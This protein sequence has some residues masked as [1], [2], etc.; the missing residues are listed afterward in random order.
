[1]ILRVSTNNAQQKLQ[2]VA[3]TIANK[4]PA[5]TKSKYQAAADRIRLPF[6]DWAK[7]LS[8]D[9]PM[10]PSIVSTEKVQV[11]FPNGTASQIGNPLYQYNFH[12]LDNTQI[13][14]TVSPLLYPIAS[15]SKL[16]RAAHPVVEK[17]VARRSATTITIPFVA[18]LTKAEV[19][20]PEST[21]GFGPI[22]SP[23]GLLYTPSCRSIRLSRKL[24]RIQC[25]EMRLELATWKHYTTTYMP[26]SH[27]G[28]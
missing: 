12:P 26:I 25:A 23:T 18:V 4:F 10:M 6:W 14:G 28:I 27:L 21:P 22:S 5:A 16:P 19:I 24:L 11:T 9:E 13:N 1:M 7:A 17:A 2:Q 8:A 15:I 3:R 20:F